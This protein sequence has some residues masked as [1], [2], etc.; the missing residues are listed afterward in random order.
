[1]GE[2]LSAINP[3]VG[4]EADGIAEGEEKD[5]NDTSVIRGMIDVMWVG[6]GQGAINL[7]IIIIS[8]GVLKFGRRSE[9]G[10]LAGSW[11]LTIIAID[12]IAQPK[13]NVFFLPSLSM[14]NISIIVHP[15][16]RVLSIPLA[17]KLKSFERPRARKTV[18]K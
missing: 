9:N 6:Q 8:S 18:G 13:S 4:S 17:I 1:M 14:I 3:C 5:E 12:M 16:F 10:G 15:I 11:K 2:Y 7:R